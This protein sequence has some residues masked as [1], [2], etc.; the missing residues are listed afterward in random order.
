MYRG[1]KK[2]SNLLNY[3]SVNCQL[4]SVYNL[5]KNVP[6]NL[7]L[8]I[9]TS[10][11]SRCQ[12]SNVI[13]S[14]VK[15]TN[16]LTTVWLAASRGSTVS[17]ISTESVLYGRCSKELWHVKT[18]PLWITTLQSYIVYI[19]FIATEVTEHACSIAV[20]Q[21]ENLWKNIQD[22]LYSRVSL[23]LI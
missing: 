10:K 9:N 1:V 21:H 6:E 4:D 3:E 16:S 13:S 5:K 11:A 19:Q 14:S 20:R 12:D 15:G 8:N 23:R 18:L 7:L 22:I 2:K 17:Y